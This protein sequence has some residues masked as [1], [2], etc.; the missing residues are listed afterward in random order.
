[1]NSTKKQSVTSRIVFNYLVEHKLKIILEITDCFV[2][3]VIKI[4][5]NN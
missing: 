1:M 5:I 4:S 2:F 3:D